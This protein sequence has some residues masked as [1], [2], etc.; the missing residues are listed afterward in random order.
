MLG[1]MLARSGRGG[2]STACVVCELWESILL[3]RRPLPLLASSGGRRRRV[4]AHSLPSPVTSQL[5]LTFFHAHAH[6]H[7]IGNATT[8]AC[9]NGQL[10][11]PV[12]KSRKVLRP[13]TPVMPSV[14]ATAPPSTSKAQE[15]A[16]DDDGA[17]T[18][19]GLVRAAIRSSISIYRSIL[20]GSFPRRVPLRSVAKVT[21]QASTAWETYSF[22]RGSHKEVVT[23]SKQLQQKQKE[24]HGGA[25]WRKAQVFGHTLR[26][27]LPPLIKSGF[28]GTAVFELY[29]ST[30]DMMD[31]AIGFDPDGEAEAA[32]STWKGTIFLSSTAVVCGGLAGAC[33]GVMYVGWEH[34]RQLMD[35]R[36]AVTNVWGG[37][38]FAHSL[39]HASLFGSFEV[40]KDALLFLTGARHEEPLGVAMVGLAGGL[41]G[42]CE[43]AVSHLTPHWEVEGVG[44][45][46][47][48]IRRHGMPQLRAI[49][50]G[51][52]PTSLGFLAWEYGRSQV[53]RQ[54]GE[55]EEEG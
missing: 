44:S 40:M 13:P 48:A 49:S 50:A 4:Q 2:P 45:L 21:D 32:T 46:K 11:E 55:N 6:P 29:E 24:G 19:A 15:E 52:L 1:S 26:G 22:L 33:H 35:S 34:G 16:Y 36:Y 3:R 23:E 41:A 30:K 12:A 39:A 28:L 25:V 42:L 43:E 31:D 17:L 7:N 37:T 20:F 18:E 10:L 38:A 51:A 54:A 5:E 27:A 53:L 8:C 9:L 14:P 47:V